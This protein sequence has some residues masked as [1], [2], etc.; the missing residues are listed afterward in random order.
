MTGTNNT[1]F[2]NAL[3]SLR[4]VAAAVRDATERPCVSGALGQTVGDQVADIKPGGPSNSHMAAVLV[5]AIK[6]ATGRRGWHDLP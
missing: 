5:M 2:L 6:N 1:I 3:E 4:P